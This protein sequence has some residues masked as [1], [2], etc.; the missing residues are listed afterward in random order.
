MCLSIMAAGGQC[1]ASDGRRSAISKPISPGSFDAHRNRSDWL[2]RSNRSN[3]RDRR[4]TLDRSHWLDRSHR[5]DWSN[6]RDG[7]GGSMREISANFQ[8]FS[9]KKV[10][11]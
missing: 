10:P 1:R 8:S 7:A 9:L 4:D 2:D 6:R 3:R 11:S 5:R